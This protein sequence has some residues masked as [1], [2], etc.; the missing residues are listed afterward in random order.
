MISNIIKVM[1][2][3]QIITQ[4]LK[5]ADPSVPILFGLAVILLAAKFGEIIAIKLKQPGVLGELII[6][7]ILGNLGFLGITLFDDLAQSQVIGILASI[8]VIVLLFQ[9]GLETKIHEMIK[10]GIR[11]LMVANVGVLAPFVLGFFA[12]G[13]LMPETPLI[14]KLFMGGILT[15]T[16]VGITVRVL[17]DLNSSESEESKIILGAAVIDDIFGL[18]ILAILSGVA[19]SGTIVFGEALKIFSIANIFVFI[20]IFLSIVI[21]KKQFTYPK[22]LE[23]PG[24]ILVFA[25]SI[26][27]F[28]AFLADKAGLATII[29]AFAAGLI[30]EGLVFKFESEENPLGLFE[31]KHKIREYIHPLAVFFVPVFF[32]IT[33]MHVK[34][35]V[36]QDLNILSTALIITVLAII[37]KLIS[38]WAFTSKNKLDRFLIGS[39]MIPRGEVGLIFAALAKD[40]EIIGDKLYVISVIMIILTTL[41]G[42]ALM[43]MRL[44]KN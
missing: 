39:G 41:I 29:G 21:A 38:G 15:A 31:V 17:R 7:I 3:E 4:A 5:H 27:F 10:V 19:I 9:V 44:K 42:P 25:I 33:G 32:V 14:A 18:I 34:L 13:F 40:L 35:S 24:T 22:I 30:L 1:E 43:A 12:I 8:G 26:C 6:G 23:I 2:H 16:S 20:A 28:C 36:F 37:G 11:S